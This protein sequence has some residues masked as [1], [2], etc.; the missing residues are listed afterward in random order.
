MSTDKGLLKDKGRIWVL[1]ESAAVKAFKEVAVV[2]NVTVSHPSN[3]VEV[4]TPSGITLLKTMDMGAQIAFDF[5]HP[6]DAKDIE[7]L[8]RG[9]VV[10][11][12]NDGSTTVAGEEVVLNFR[13]ASEALPLPGYNG[14]KTAV[15][16]NSVKL[17]SDLTTT[18]SVTTDYTLT[19]DPETGITLLVQVSGGG[20]PVGEDIIVNYDYDPLEAQILKPDD[21]TDLVDRFIVIDSFP[22]CNDLTKYRRYFLPRMTITSDLVHSMIEMG[23]DN[24]NPNLMNVTLTYNKPST[25][26]DEHKWYWID[27]YNPL[28]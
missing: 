26:S 24:Q 22:D 9:P 5:Y 17:V 15:T 21:N 11:T 18:Y 27:T 20:I 25:C 6:G 23:A 4:K 19:A 3:P 1:D 12:A 13:N 16:V 14:D 2:D 8:F 10:R 28:Q 7:R